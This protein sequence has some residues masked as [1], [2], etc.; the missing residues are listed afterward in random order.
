M[1]AR[2]L[3][4]KSVARRLTEE[5]A[6]QARMLTER[7]GV[8][9]GLGVV[10]VGDAPA[11]VSYVTAKER[12]CAA[13]GF[14]SRECRLPATA[15]PAELMAV[16]RGLNDDPA[17]HG[18]LVQLP[19]PR[20][21]DEQAAIAAIHPDKDVDGFTPVNVGRMMIGQPCF[22]PCTPHGIIHLLIDSGIETKGRHAVVVGRSN[23][24]GKPV[25][26]LLMRKAAGGN[27]TVTVCHT[28]TP[29]LADFTRQA[30]IL[31]VA[32]GRPRTVTGA[33]IKPGA[34]VIDVGV[35]RI[36]DATAP[37]GYRLVG[38]VDFTSASEV[39]GC[40]T[41]VPGGVGP[42]TIA[43]LMRNTFEAARRAANGE[44][45]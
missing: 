43:M 40:L 22:L 24:V 32:A 10:L 42:L 28:A 3:D 25:A 4:G 19:L 44:T 35:N 18:I 41:P 23:I 12:A 38:D 29:D 8:V 2:I 45:T 7:T 13:L 39:A 31:V 15:T 21:I 16:I 26:H 30:D 33:M 5:T 37:K 1:A 6:R 14:L 11:S 17:I 9:P 27:A 36:A 20:Q 34:A